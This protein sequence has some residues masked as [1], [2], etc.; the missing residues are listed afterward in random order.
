MVD[1]MRKQLIDVCLMR[2]V[3][4]LDWSLAHIPGSVYYDLLLNQQIGDPFFRE[5]ESALI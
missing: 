5:N 1:A 2:R 4:D 3:G